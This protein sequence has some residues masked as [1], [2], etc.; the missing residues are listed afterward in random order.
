M[1]LD[2]VARSISFPT[3]L[4]WIA[5]RFREEGVRRLTFGHSSAEKAAKA[6]RSPR[7]E[8]SNRAA[9]Q[10]VP[11]WVKELMHRLTA[12]AAGTPDDFLDVPVDTGPLSQFHRRIVEHC[13][14]IAYGETTTYGQLGARC[15]A[16]RAARAVGNCMAANPIPLLIPCHR[17]VRSDG[18]AGNYS[19]PGGKKMKQRL[20]ALEAGKR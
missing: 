16:P 14:Q 6:V 1:E 12:Y 7:Q 17:V 8:V 2:E 3:Q 13:R 10:A 15:G 5:L 4:G 20:L 19:A 9:Q 11:A 18:H